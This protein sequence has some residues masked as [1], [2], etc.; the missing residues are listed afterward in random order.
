M[1]KFL[2]KRTRSVALLDHS[3]LLAPTSY[4]METLQTIRPIPGAVLEVTSER[5]HEPVDN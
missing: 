5:P 3:L 2:D 4:A 1:A